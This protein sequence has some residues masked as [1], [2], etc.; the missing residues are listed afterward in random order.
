MGV[1][2]TCLSNS[3]TDAVVEQPVKANGRCDGRALIRLW[4]NKHGPASKGCVVDESGVC[5]QSI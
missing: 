5:A 2:G 1:A 4:Q 3:G